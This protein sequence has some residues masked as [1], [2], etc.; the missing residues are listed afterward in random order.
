[1]DNE[2]QS[3]DVW[4]VDVQ[5]DE[6]R[7]RAGGFL[8][9]NLLDDAITIATVETGVPLV[10]FDAARVE[11]GTPK[12]FQADLTYSWS[13]RTIWGIDGSGARPQAISGD[14]VAVSRPPV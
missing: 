8:S 6:V 14:N 10:A 12:G 9:R 7:L 3:V 2:V 4:Q 11:Y 1:M 5:K 13:V